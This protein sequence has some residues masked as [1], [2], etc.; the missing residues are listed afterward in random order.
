MATKGNPNDIKNNKRSKLFLSRNNRDKEHRLEWVEFLEKNNLKD[1]YSPNQKIPT[2]KS[3][4]LYFTKF[5]YNLGE[6]L[7]I[8]SVFSRSMNNENIF[9]NNNKS[10]AGNVFEFDVNLDSIEF[11]SL[12]YGFI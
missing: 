8:E 11:K 2:P 7:S 12:K 3:R 4:N 5:L 1:Y 9:S 6:N 10:L